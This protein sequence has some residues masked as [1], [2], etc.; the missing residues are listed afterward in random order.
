MNSKIS[1]SQVV[2]PKKLLELGDEW[3]R[4]CSVTPSLDPR[5]TG[6][7]DLSFP[8]V[9]GWLSEIPEQQRELLV[10]TAKSGAKLIGVLPLL[11]QDGPDGMELTLV[12]AQG[13]FGDRKGIIA[14]GDDQAR[15][16]EAF[17]NFLAKEWIGRLAKLNLQSVAKEA[18]GIHSLV[19]T[20]VTH[21]TWS[22][23]SQQES[24]QRFVFR[25]NLGPDGEP[26]WPL[27]SRRTM[28]LVRKAYSSGLFEYSETSEGKDS[29]QLVN[30]ALA[31]RGMLKNDASELKE[32]FGSIPMAQRLIDY[33][34]APGT[35]ASLANVGNLRACT[36]TWKN[37]PIAGAMFVDYGS[38][39]YVFWTEVRVHKDQ[40]QLI[41]WMLFSNLV[42]SS[43]H[44]GLSELQFASAL[45]SRA[46]GFKNHALP[47]YT[48]QAVPNHE[49]APKASNTSERATAIASH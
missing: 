30:H 28:N 18:V 44:A 22:A 46:T 42:R 3:N 25:P 16:G 10:L 5:Q 11:I 45:G 39:R 17:G 41:F 29:Q 36:L 38:T 24:L 1:V 43:L 20:L 48:I 34:F 21:S 27:A 40:E 49:L 14:Y 13:C 33:R 6:A 26:I 12:G 7:W 4:L 37:T 32:R 23:S 15:V 9:L 19:N 47:V 8:W 35:P 2:D 31:I